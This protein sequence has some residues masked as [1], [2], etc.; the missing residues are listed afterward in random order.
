MFRK[1]PHLD[2]HESWQMT[3][4]NDET[5]RTFPFPLAGQ[6]AIGEIS[7]QICTA[8]SYQGRISKFSEEANEL[9][10]SALRAL[11]DY[12]QRDDA[13]SR[14]TFVQAFDRLSD[15]ALANSAL[16]TAIEQAGYHFF[17]DRMDSHA[18][19]V[20]QLIELVHEARQLGMS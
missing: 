5:E 13:D 14:K 18:Q 19:A 17:A 6:I 10:E 1:H 7:D 4:P 16:F 8:L 9:V 20:L 2:S 12:R 3:N 11:A 15:Y